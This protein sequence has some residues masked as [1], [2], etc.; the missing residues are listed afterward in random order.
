MEAIKIKEAINQIGT[1]DINFGEGESF[2]LMNGTDITDLNVS[3]F[4]LLKDDFID[5]LNTYLINEGGVNLI[6]DLLNSIALLLENL[7]REYHLNRVKLAHLSDSDFRFIEGY[8][9]IIHLITLKMNLLEGIE[10]ELKLIIDN[11]NFKTNSDF[12]LDRTSNDSISEY[13]LQTTLNSMD[14]NLTERIDNPFPN[15]FRNYDAY[16][17]FERLKKNICTDQTTQLAD[18]SYVYRKMLE[19]KF[20]NDEVSPS[21]FVSFLDKNY[22]IVLDPLKSWGK[23]TGKH[24]VMLYEILKTKSS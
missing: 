20:I 16:Q 23:L 15:I 2:F 21:S 5:K 12:K 11:Y 18:Y 24:R 8:K 3:T 14:D 10:T 9:K 19:D 22:N 4:D 13:N 6:E 1:I 7:L 17:F